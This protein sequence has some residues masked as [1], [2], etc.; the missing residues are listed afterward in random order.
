MKNTR[1]P[2]RQWSD[3]EKLLIVRE[4]QQSGDSISGFARRHN[5]GLSNLRS[6]IESHG[7]DR[8]VGAA[9]VELTAMLPGEEAGE[10]HY[11]LSLI[12]GHTLKLRRGFDS[13]EAAALVAA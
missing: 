5:V 13:L 7:E 11:E 8:S 9:L 10:C 1:R 6:R 3:E 12:S 4:Y 2:R